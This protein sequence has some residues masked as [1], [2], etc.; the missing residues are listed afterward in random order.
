MLNHKARKIVAWSLISCISIL[1]AALLFSVNISESIA[2]NIEQPLPEQV[3]NADTVL[4]QEPH[5]E[6]SYSVGI[7]V[8]CNVTVK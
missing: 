7:S 3:K 1:A 2:D 5:A 8:R 6:D 4:P